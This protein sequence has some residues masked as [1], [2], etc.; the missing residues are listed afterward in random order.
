MLD[1]TKDTMIRAYLT[2]LR[3]EGKR[4]SY[5]NMPMVLSIWAFAAANADCCTEKEIIEGLRQEGRVSVER[6]ATKAGALRFYDV[7]GAEV[8]LHRPCAKGKPGVPT[9]TPWGAPQTVEEYAPGVVKISTA[10]HGGFWLDDKAMEKMPSTCRG[11]LWAG[12]SNWFEED[13]DWSWVALSYPELF[14]RA[15]V[16]AARRTFEGWIRPKLDQRGIKPKLPLPI[17]LVQPSA[18]MQAGR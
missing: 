10:G 13:V 7:C 14:P 15:H 17:D 18:F 8:W 4:T 5:M 2:E 16:E 3:P 12:R 9:D 1:I 6:N 11:A